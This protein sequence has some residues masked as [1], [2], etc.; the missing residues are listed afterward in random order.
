MNDRSNHTLSIDVVSDVM[1]PWCYIGKRRLDRARELNPQIGTDI[2]WRP[3]QLDATIPPEGMDRKDY[4]DRKFGP[5][6]SR[7]I[8]ARIEATGEAEG[9]PF[10]FDRIEKS[11]NTLDAHRLIRWSASAARQDAVVEKLFSLFFVEGE[12]IGDREVLIGAARDA[13]MD[14]D[15]VRELLD[16]GAD[17]ELV[18]RE[19]ALA[20]QLGV[21]GVPAF[22]F[23]NRY[24]VMG[25]QAPELIAKAMQQ[26]SEETAANDV[27]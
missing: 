23:A 2:R 21:E 18:E 25:A 27:Y 7:E 17:A 9:I 1:C 22:I 24:V 8:Y 4:L 19:V 15:L 13:G 6:R 12:D 5:D 14:V 26:A 3:F 10:A 20:H 16:S 11:P